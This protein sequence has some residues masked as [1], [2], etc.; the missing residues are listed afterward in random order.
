VKLWFAAEESVAGLTVAAAA[1]SRAN[2]P[3][4]EDVV[5]EALGVVSATVSCHSAM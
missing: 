1:I 3:E 5:H 4:F 2:P